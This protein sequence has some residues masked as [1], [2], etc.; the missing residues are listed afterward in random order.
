MP[1]MLPQALR[2]AVRIPLL[3]F[4]ISCSSGPPSHPQNAVEQEEASSQIRINVAKALGS[5]MI[6]WPRIEKPK[7]AKQARIHGVVKLD[8]VIS[9]TGEVAAIHIVSGEPSQVSAAVR[10]VEDY[11]TAPTYLNGKPVEIKAQVEVPFTLDE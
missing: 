10:A 5:N 9:K 8:I 2:S 11:R 7:E 6:Y 3:L 4:L 1:L